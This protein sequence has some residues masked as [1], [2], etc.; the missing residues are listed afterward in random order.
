MNATIPFVVGLLICSFAGNLSAD[1]PQIRVSVQIEGEGDNAGDAH[2]LSALS[3]EFRK[4]DGV[5][6]T[7]TQPA[8]KV[9]CIQDALQ[10]QL[11]SGSKVMMAYAASVAVTAADGRLVY[12]LLQTNRT[13]DAL[14]HEIALAL[15]GKLIER[16]RRAAEPSSS[17]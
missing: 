14:A 9:L 1:T 5:S 8:L 10:Y 13:I 11:P 2:M 12:H 4:L 17:P 6:V 3:R 15:D 7:D 16:M